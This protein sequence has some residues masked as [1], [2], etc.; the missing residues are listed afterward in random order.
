MNLRSYFVVATL[1]LTTVATALLFI[2]PVSAA[3]L[4]QAEVD[5][6]V[7]TSST[8]FTL[9]VL[10]DE[11]TTVAIPMQVD[12]RAEGPNEGNA[13]EAVV[14]IV[15]TVLRTGF[16]SVTVGAVEPSLGTLTVTLA[17]PEDEVVPITRTATTTGTGTTTETVPVTTTVGVPVTGTATA[18][19]VS[20]LREGPGTEYAIVGSA[21]A[22]DALDIVGQNAD[23]TW[24]VLA[25]GTWVAAFLVDNAPT[26]LPVVEPTATPVLPPGATNVVTPTIIPT[27]TPTP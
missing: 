3:P 23:G 19:A 11:V 17:E 26:G 15:P 7:V 13:D 4:A 10:I 8:T 27:V 16:F 24:F 25:N 22:G 9:T 2:A 20:N 14:T 5:E 1:F 6:V 18:N 12:W 21:N